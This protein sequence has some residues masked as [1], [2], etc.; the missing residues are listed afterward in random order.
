VLL[1][2][3]V[4][5]LQGPVSLDPH[6]YCVVCGPYSSW[7]KLIQTKRKVKS[8]SEVTLQIAT[9]I[10]IH[11]YD[12][13]PHRVGSRA[14]ISIPG[15]LISCPHRTK[16]T[17]KQSK[18]SCTASPFFADMYCQGLGPWSGPGHGWLLV[19]LRLFCIAPH[20]VLQVSFLSLSTYT[21]IIDIILLFL[22]YVGRFPVALVNSV[23]RSDVVVIAPTMVCS[24]EQ[25]IVA[26]P[27]SP[28]CYTW[29]SI[30][31]VF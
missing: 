31:I 1:L 25:P 24:R 15:I 5:K 14:A 6:I 17:S 10:H 7:C 3:L 16:I 20:Q 4:C 27:C 8:S 9:S 18:L 29:I 30:G 13:G 2:Y 12:A 11:D 23:N 28:A 21:P 26:S 22:Q 19:L